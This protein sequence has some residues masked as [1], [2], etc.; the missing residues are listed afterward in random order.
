MKLRP[1][2]CCMVVCGLWGACRHILPEAGR[3]VVAEVHDKY[4]YEDELQQI[5]PSGLQAEDSALVVEKYI[6]KWATDILM[7]EKAKNNISDMTEIDRLVDEYRKTLTIHQYQ[8]RLV[9][10]YSPQEPQEEEI[11]SFYERYGG[12][13]IVKENLLKGLFLVVPAD[14]PRM[15]D[16]RSWV[17]KADT[18]SLEQIDKYTL[19]NAVSYDYFMDNWLPLLTITRKAPF[20]IVNPAEF[21]SAHSLAE[22]SDSAHHYFLKISEYCTVGQQEPYD[23]ARE[24]IIKVLSAQSSGE[25][26][27]QM[28]QELYQDAVASKDLKIYK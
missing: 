7:Y 3:K 13:M 25:L 22:A 14:A 1:V 24:K 21:L 12:Q 9:E 5:I 20:Q 4:L 10:Q 2:L 28:E 17:K 19:Q 23:L 18:E 11:R 8:Q 16:V 6:R 26:I 15:D 27:S